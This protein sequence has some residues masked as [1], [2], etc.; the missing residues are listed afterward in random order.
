MPLT[1]AVVAGKYQSPNFQ[2]EFAGQVKMAEGSDSSL[3]HPLTKFKYR[4][5]NSVKQF[6]FPATLWWEQ[7]R[8]GNQDRRDANGRSKTRPKT[9]A[10]GSYYLS[11]IIIQCMWAYRRCLY[12]YRDQQC[13]SQA[14]HLFRWYRHFRFGLSNCRSQDR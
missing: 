13:P 2:D 1:W 14:I 3:L 10:C 6:P 11:L 5:S 12:P 9:S 4:F 8:G 7:D